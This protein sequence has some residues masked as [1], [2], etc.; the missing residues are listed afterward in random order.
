VDGEAERRLMTTNERTATR[1]RTGRRPGLRRVVFRSFPAF[2]AIAL[3]FAPSA[4]AATTPRPTPQPTPQPTAQL[5]V[6]DV[7][8]A[9]PGAGTAVATFV[10]SLSE[11]SPQTVSVHYRTADGSATAPADYR[12]VSG[13]LSLPPGETSRTV[14]VTVRANPVP[15][16]EKV[17]YLQL[18]K[19][20]NA[21]I[22]RPQGTATIVDNLPTIAVND[23]F[24]AEPAPGAV[25]R[26]TFTVSL[27]AP[28]SRPVTV[29]FTTA[30]GSAV[31]G[32]DYEPLSGVL[33]FRPGEGSTTIFVN[34]TNDLV[35]S[36]DEIFFL[37]LS[38]PSN[39]QLARAA[40]QATIVD[41]NRIL[42]VS[43]SA[44]QQPESGAQTIATFQVI[45]SEPSS[46]S[47]QPVAG[48]PTD[49][50][51]T[52]DFT[53]ADG[54]AVAGQDYLPVSGTL[55]FPP[56]V[57]VETISIPVMNNGVPSA[58]KLFFVKLSNPHNA[59]LARAVGIATIQPNNRVVTIEDTTVTDADAPGTVAS[60]VVSLSVPSSDPVT[61]RY[62]T[63]D[64]TALAGVDYVAQNG[65][66]VFPP[67]QASMT[68]A[69]PILSDVSDQNPDTPE[70][71]YV[72]LSDAEN[73]VIARP[74]ATGTIV[75]NDQFIS[76]ADTS[77]VAD[78]N[79]SVEA[80]FT[81]SLPQAPTTPVR[82]DFTTA[83]GTATA[84]ADYQ[85]SSGTVS[86]AAGE[87]TATI[88]VPIRPQPGKGPDRTFHVRLS[89][90]VNG[91]IQRGD[92]TGTILTRGRGYR[93]V[94]ADGGIFAFGDAGFFGSTGA[95]ALNHPIVG[96]AATPSGN[97]YWLVA[98][99][100]GIFA[101]GD[102]GFFGSTGAVAL[103]QPIVGMAA[104][105][106]GNGYWLVAADG[107]VFAFGDA[108]FF[109]AADQMD[110]KEAV[111]GVAPTPDGNGYWLVAADGGVFAFGDARLFGPT[112]GI[113]ANEPIV[114][115]TRSG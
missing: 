53:T 5:G 64:G 36:Q 80:V 45:L 112:R 38:N 56:G 30:D 76:V 62:A 63:V 78:P 88:S 57:S 25:N 74:R 10:V 79:A 68:I 50:T 104:T 26:A 2:L 84:S 52:V 28:S 81:V 100:G 75:D 102:A 92:A 89:G 108:H 105:P 97:G 37:K 40:G 106:S 33:T 48:F 72:D 69:V 3:V 111:V 23:T 7:T 6:A 39:G 27:S 83:D 18:L 14:T 61:V 99:D 58:E 87:T 16:A 15:A 20:S 8:I 107:G 35:S 85:S 21:A 73:A 67:G 60:F 96:M 71:F 12:P 51:T 49:V 113:T 91:K 31:A 9:A 11:Q 29:D 54:S 115:M 70:T 103:N 41:A 86:I 101:F 110:L 90:A 22:S 55:V 59:S 82:V 93:L 1:P 66:L 32:K 17:F 34:V 46:G 65:T 43:D 114:G 44:I 77:V 42:S 98:A 13:T 95:V 109:G 4:L 19:A 47:T 94:A 24:I